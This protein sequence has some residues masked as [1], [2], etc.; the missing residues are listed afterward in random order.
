MSFVPAVPTAPASQT[1][2]KPVALERKLWGT[3]RGGPCGGDLTF[4]S[5]GVFERR[6][7]GPANQSLSGTWVVQWNALPPTLVL[8]CTDADWAGLI[9]TKQEL[10][11]V[12]LDDA[13]LAYL[14]AGSVDPT[15]Y[16]RVKK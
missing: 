3:W 9:G 1:E 10:K 15:H 16:K 13:A 12:Q 14:Y 7:Y 11:I 5:N 4:K 6:H 8:T 2:G